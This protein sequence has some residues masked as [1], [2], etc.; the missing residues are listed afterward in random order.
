MSCLIWFQMVC[1]SY[2]QM[3]IGDREIKCSLVPVKI[4]SRHNKQTFL[5]QSKKNSSIK[6][7]APPGKFFMLSADFFFRN[8]L[9]QK[10]NSVWIQIRPDVLSGLIWVQTVCKSYQQTTLGLRRRRVK[11]SRARDS[12]FF[13]P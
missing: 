8:Q 9:L 11:K 12:I 10:I 1:K 7:V 4:C 3:T 13:C 6:F 5:E 2:Q